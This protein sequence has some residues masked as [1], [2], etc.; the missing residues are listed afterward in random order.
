MRVDDGRITSLLLSAR[1]RRDFT[2]LTRG[3]VS[4]AEWDNAMAKAASKIEQQFHQAMLDVYEAAR[5]LTPPYHATRFLHMVNT[6]GG[7]D[8]ADALLATDQP[9][10]GFTELFLRGRRLDLSVEYLVLRTPY[11]DLFT[12]EQRAVARER[13]KKHEFKPPPEDVG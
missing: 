4:R 3:T 13:L 2:A 1:E 10:E 5:R 11:R 9:S 6:R 7:R 8:A 12:P